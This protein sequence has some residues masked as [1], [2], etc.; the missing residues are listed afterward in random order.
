MYTEP[1]AF[2]R[3]IS[4][5]A[6]I[7]DWRNKYHNFYAKNGIAYLLRRKGGKWENQQQL[8][9]ITAT[10]ATKNKSIINISYEFICW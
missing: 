1:N 4:I 7:G 9:T 8:N 10:A 3:V 6:G 5:Y 2:V